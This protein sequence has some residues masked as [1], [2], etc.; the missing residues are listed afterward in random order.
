MDALVE[1]AFKGNRKEF[2]RWDGD[3]PLA[4][5]AAVIVEADRGEDLGSVHSV[6]DEARIRNDRLAH[7]TKEE[8][9]ARRILR[10]ASEADVAQAR[11]LREQED[12]LAR[13]RARDLVKQHGLL[14]KVTDAEWQFDRMKLTLYFTADK[15]VDFRAL[16]RDLASTFRARIELKQIGVRDEAR[17]LSGIGRCGREYCS[18]SWLPEL[19][20]VNLGIAKDQKLSL[21]PT[22]ISGA[23]GRLMCCLRYEH[24]FYVQSRKRFPKEGKVLVTSMGEEKVIAN[25]IF[26]ETVRLRNADGD[27]RDLPLSRLKRELAIA[28]GAAPD[29]YED[30]DSVAGS[31]RTLPVVREMPASAEVA[32]APAGPP[33]A[34][35]ADTSSPAPTSVEGTDRRSATPSP[36]EGAPRKRHRRGRRG[37]RR[38]RG[39]GHGSGR[40]EPGDIASG[41]DH[42]DSDD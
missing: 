15:R 8:P 26:R 17:R 11:I 41:R 16:V 19:L 6:G 34:G 14:M 37:G 27:V 31:G 42:N 1:V 24:E 13:H 36:E 30:T 12:E 4:V 21:N 5:K 2:V 18:A 20:P 9:P 35:I 39:N 10:L 28:S 33:A 3:E 29:D 7:G 22:Q 25:D 38:S 32:Q 40:A 23:C